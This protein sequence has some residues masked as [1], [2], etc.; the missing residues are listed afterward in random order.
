MPMGQEAKGYQRR[1]IFLVFV[2][3]VPTCH[4]FVA[5]PP[6]SRR[7]GHPTPEGRGLIVALSS[8]TGPTLPD[9]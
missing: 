7:E 1:W 4:H 5:E 2:G 8:P 6:W 9:T 3:W